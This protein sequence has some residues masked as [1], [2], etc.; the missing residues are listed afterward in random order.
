MDLPLVFAIGCFSSYFVMIAGDW[1]T[2]GGVPKALALPENEGG[3]AKI[4]RT[5]VL[6]H[7]RDR[8]DDIRDHLVEARRR[9]G[10]AR[11]WP[12]QIIPFLVA[13]AAASIAVLDRSPLALAAAV[14]WLAFPS[15][16]RWEVR[17]VLARYDRIEAALDR[18]RRYDGLRPVDPSPRAD[19][20]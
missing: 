20:A 6:P 14:G 4:L 13:A 5:G 19:Q 1:I 3:F 18:R 8:D 11:R 17:R 10:V 16:S 15:A 7:A 2:D 12:L 9:I